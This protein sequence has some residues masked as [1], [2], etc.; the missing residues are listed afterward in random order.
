MLYQRSFRAVAQF[1][2]QRTRMIF[3]YGDEVILN[4]TDDS[5]K[6]VEK[7]CVVVSITPVENDQQSKHFKY[8]IGTLLYTVEFGDGTDKLV[9]ERDLRPAGPET[10]SR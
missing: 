7:R 4:L 8:P 9:A 2:R 6:V 3:D 5:G 1:Y 10:P